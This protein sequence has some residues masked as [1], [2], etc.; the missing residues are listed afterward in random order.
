MTTIG[1]LGANL[2]AA[3]KTAA[4]VLLDDTCTVKRPTRTEDDNGGVSYAYPTVGTYACLVQ[5]AGKR[6]GQEDISGERIT[7]E[8]RLQA[9]F[10][11]GTVIRQQDHV[12][13]AS[14]GMTYVVTNEIDNTT[15]SPLITVMIA[16]ASA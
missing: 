9:S 7:N 10:P 12:T 14:S 13:Q 16:F 5:S 2:L 3:C 11:A 15:D 8:T 1:G 6:L 4:K